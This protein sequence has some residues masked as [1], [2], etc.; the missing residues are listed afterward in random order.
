MDMLVVVVVMANC[1]RMGERSKI[2][3]EPEVEVDGN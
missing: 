3:K 1:L 2:C